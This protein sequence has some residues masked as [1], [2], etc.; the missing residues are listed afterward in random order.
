MSEVPAAVAGSKVSPDER[1]RLA[2]IV[3]ATHDRQCQELNLQ[4]ECILAQRTS[5][6]AR[7]QAL[8]AALLQIET[9]IAALA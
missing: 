4:R 8:E 1:K 5:S 7:R 6:P 2:A 9:Q 3:R